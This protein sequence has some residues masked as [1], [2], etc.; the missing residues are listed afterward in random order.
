MK[1]KTVNFCRSSSRAS[2]IFIRLQSNFWNHRQILIN[3]CIRN[4]R[5]DPRVGIWDASCG[6]TDGWT[7]GYEDARVALR[8]MLHK[9]PKVYLSSSQISVHIFSS[10]ATFNFSY[11]NIQLSYVHFYV[12]LYIYIYI[13]IYIHTHTHT[14]TNT[15]TIFLSVCHVE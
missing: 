6:Q 4:I 7:Y 15:H 10:Q 12:F 14:H 8:Q 13:Y 5:T 9:A 11:T 3:V 1:N 2:G